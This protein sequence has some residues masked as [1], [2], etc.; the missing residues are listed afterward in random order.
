MRAFILRVGSDRP[1]VLESGRPVASLWG[2]AGK[3]GK[4]DLSAPGTEQEAGGWIR[5]SGRIRRGE[6][7]PGRGGGRL[8]K[9]RCV[10]ILAITAGSSMAARMVNGPPHCGQVVISMANTRLSK[11]LF[12][13]HNRFSFTM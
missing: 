1:I 6:R 5:L 11:R 3:L 7:V 8:G 4:G 12:G 10:R 2:V 13:T 9:P